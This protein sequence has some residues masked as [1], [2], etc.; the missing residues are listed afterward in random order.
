[1]AKG[2]KLFSVFN[3]DIASGVLYKNKSLKKLIIHYLDQNGQSTITELSKE[4]NTSVPKITGLIISSILLIME[5]F[6]SSKSG[7]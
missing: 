2:T 7:E 3:D 6:A 1:M 4:L 5:F